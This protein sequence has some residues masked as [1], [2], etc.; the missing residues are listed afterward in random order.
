MVC[1][2][3]SKGQWILRVAIAYNGTRTTVRTVQ[4]VRTYVRAYSYCTG[5]ALG[6]CVE[7]LGCRNYYYY[8]AGKANIDAPL[9]ELNDKS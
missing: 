1:I 4:L 7:K 5:T 8:I 3:K 6:R 9:I 2:C